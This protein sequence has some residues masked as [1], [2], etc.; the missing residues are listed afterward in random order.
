MTYVL[1][2][3]I[4]DKYSGKTL[5]KS[6]VSFAVPPVVGDVVFWKDGLGGATVMARYIGPDWI[7]LRLGEVG[8]QE[9]P[10]FL[11]DGWVLH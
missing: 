5:T 6:D 1:V 10:E 11:K 7:E 8:P 3:R 2:Y 9:I 4:K